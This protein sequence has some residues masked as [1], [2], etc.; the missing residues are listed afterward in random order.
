V[1][2]N[3][4]TRITIPV[5][6]D[7]VPGQHCFL[8]FPSFGFH[9]LT[10]HPFTMC[11]L[12]S[13]S[14]D[15]QSYAVFYIRHRRGLTSRLHDTASKSPN[16][17]I[18]VLVDGP[19]G[20]I[21]PA[22]YTG[23]DRILVVAG[24]SGAGWM[25]PFIEQFGRF[26][27][28][29]SGNLNQT[30]KSKIPEPNVEC[31]TLSGGKNLPST[32]RLI[33]ATRDS[34]TRTWFHK[35]TRDLLSEYSGEVTSLS[36]ENQVYLTGN[37]QDTVT[38]RKESS[39]SSSSPPAEKAD[40]ESAAPSKP[41]DYT[42]L[43]RPSSDKSEPFDELIGRPPLSRIIAEEAARS[44]ETRQSLGVFVCGPVTMQNDVR[45]AVAQANLEMVRNPRGGGVYLHVEHFSWA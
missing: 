42:Q 43:H 30:P 44:A 32:M 5:D 28:L 21:T 17:S 18:P 19:Y 6:F 23:S 40:I 16:V 36:I 2:D 45:N 11:S 7:W 31:Q 9:A 34:S 26:D 10:S 14:A 13:I 33:L 38:T 4:F 41:D 24:G 27:M 25:L 22:R 39:E 12:P 37:A 20:G 8:R 15:K 35:A 3:G 29:R 1:E